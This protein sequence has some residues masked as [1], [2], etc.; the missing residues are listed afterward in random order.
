MWGR[1]FVPE[2]LVGITQTQE[3]VIEIA[4]VKVADP[5]KDLNAKMAEQPAPKVAE[6]ELF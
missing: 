2:L 4:E 3:E 5:A 6:D 1:L